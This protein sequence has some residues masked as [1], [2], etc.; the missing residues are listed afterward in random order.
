MERGGGEERSAKLVEI[1]LPRF[2]RRKPRE[3]FS[4]PFDSLVAELSR[5]AS[6]S[7]QR[8]GKG[9]G[10]GFAVS[11]N[12]RFIDSKS[13]DSRIGVSRKILKKEKKKGKKRGK[14]EEK[15]KENQKKKRG[16]EK[17]RNEERENRIEFLVSSSLPHPAP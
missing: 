8:E 11:R 9:G 14:K 5:F 1:K 15:K 3:S 10:I 16:N 2:L 4:L 12:S 17:R 13:I 6:W 7:G